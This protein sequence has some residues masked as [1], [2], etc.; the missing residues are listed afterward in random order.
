MVELPGEQ[1]L[2]RLAV[3]AERGLEGLG[4]LEALVAAVVE[5]RQLRTDFQS[6][7]LGTGS[8][9]SASSTSGDSERE[10]VWGR[11]GTREAEG[12]R[13][14]GPRGLF[15]SLSLTHQI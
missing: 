1:A 7:F 5:L 11:D 2:V 9:A 14:R 13:A 3:E 6:L 12:R 8:K 15:L 10:R 4:V